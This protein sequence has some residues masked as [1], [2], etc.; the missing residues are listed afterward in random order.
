MSTIW[1]KHLS[2]DKMQTTIS[3]AHASIGKKVFQTEESGREYADTPKK[4][5]LQEFPETPSK[6]FSKI[7][8]IEVGT[9]TKSNHHEKNRLRRRTVMRFLWL[10]PSS[11]RYHFSRKFEN[12]S[13]TFRL[14]SFCTGLVSACISQMLVPKQNRNCY[15][16]RWWLI[17]FLYNNRI[18]VVLDHFWR[19][20]KVSVF[21][22]L[23]VIRKVGT[24]QPVSTSVELIYPLQ[25]WQK[26]TAISLWFEGAVT[27]TIYSG[28]HHFINRK[29]IWRTLHKTIARISGDS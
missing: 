14:W 4:P 1:R 22:Y 8:H 13:S 15:F 19:D 2:V 23:K 20:F 28:I 26:P 16:Y 24:T 12:S 10:C 29:C 18:F 5:L 17:R 27:A 21:S 25:S 7:V 9:V 11:C 3:T 6:S